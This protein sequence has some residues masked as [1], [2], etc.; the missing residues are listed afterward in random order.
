MVRRIL[1]L[2]HRGEPLGVGGIFF[3]DLDSGAFERD[4]AFTRSVGEAFPRGLP[5]LVRRH[6]NGRGRS[7]RALSWQARPLCRVQPAA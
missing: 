2:P 6:M 7:Q 5:R 1:H 3:D 4:F